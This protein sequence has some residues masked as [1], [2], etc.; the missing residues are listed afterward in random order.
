MKAEIIF[1]Q[2]HL[3]QH[4]AFKILQ[5]GMSFNLVLEKLAAHFDVFY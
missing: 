1:L 2:Q 5:Y 3:F 4:E